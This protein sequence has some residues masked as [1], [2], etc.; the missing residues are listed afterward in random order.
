MSEDKRLNVALNELLLL[1][2]AGAL[3]WHVGRWG[4][5]II[6]LACFF[7]GASAESIS[8]EFKKE[9]SR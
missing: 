1:V 3:G 7:L 6:G 5:V 2:V 4:G 9:E 8:R